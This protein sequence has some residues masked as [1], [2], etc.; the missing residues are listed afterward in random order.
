[1][2]SLYRVIAFFVAGTLTLA[3]CAGTGPILPTS[4]APATSGAPAPSEPA[5]ASPTSSGVGEV[6]YTCAAPPGFPLSVFD[7]PAGAEL[8]ADPAA[9][10]LRKALGTELAHGFPRSGYWLVG[11]GPTRAD[12]VARAEGGDSPFAYASFEVHDG[13]WTLWG[14]GECRPTVVLEG[15]SLATWTFDSA[16]PA[17]DNEAT[18]FTALVTERACTGGKPMAGRLL[19][20]AIT[21]GVEAISVIFAAKPLPGEHDCPGNP[22][23][24]VGVELREPL[25]DRRLLDGAFFPPAD[26]SA[27]TV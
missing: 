26:P 16:L 19:P 20:P 27:P 13:A 1:M 21:Y 4:N 25:G 6:R 11:R 17:P 18:S 5:A 8:A 12:F 7:R 3:A 23:S 22:S 10:A 14:Y 2:S 24:R 15:M 9:A